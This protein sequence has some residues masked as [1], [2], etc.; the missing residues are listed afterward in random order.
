MCY[1]NCL[2]QFREGP[3]VLDVKWKIFSRIPAWRIGEGRGGWGC[4]WRRLK[5]GRGGGGRM[6]LVKTKRVTKVKTNRWM[7][8]VRRTNYKGM[9]IG[10]NRKEQLKKR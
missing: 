6:R 5:R 1:C 2:K 10:D 8:E 9:N 4:V 3:G 7:V